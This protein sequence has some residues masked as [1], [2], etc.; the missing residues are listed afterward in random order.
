MR[1]AMPVWRKP[2]GWASI[3]YAVD[4]TLL[5]VNAFVTLPRLLT[6]AGIVLIVIGLF[7]NFR[8]LSAMRR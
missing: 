4:A 1:P 2:M 3:F 7:M 8:A 5:L 6:V